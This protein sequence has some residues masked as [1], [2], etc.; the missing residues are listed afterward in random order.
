GIFVITGPQSWGYR[1]LTDGK[2]Y[3]AISTSLW[4]GVPP[5]AITLDQ[6]E[7]RVFGTPLSWPSSDPSPPT[8]LQ[9]TPNNGR[10]TILAAL[11]HEFGHVFWSVRLGGQVP[12]SSKFCSRELS[13][14]WGTTAQRNLQGGI[15]KSFGNPD[16]NP[17]DISD[18]PSDPP[19]PGD[20]GPA[21]AKV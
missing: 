13:V 15:W 7:N 14:A 16:N 18:D 11:A 4:S 19:Q 9:A 10:M 6:Y 5:K 2:Q 17:A 3:I 20:P 12:Q 21:E 1:S 8:Y